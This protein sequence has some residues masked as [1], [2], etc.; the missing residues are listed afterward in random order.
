[1]G[2]TKKE[3][4]RDESKKA[5]E[6]NKTA[7]ERVEHYL[8][9]VNQDFEKLVSDSL[10]KCD[11]LV[12]FIATCMKNN[13]NGLIWGDGGFGKSDAIR[14]IINTINIQN[15]TYIMSFGNDTTESD[16]WG[17]LDMDAFFSEDQRV[18]RYKV[19]ESFLNYPFVVFEEMLDAPASALTPLKNTLQEKRL[20]LGGQTYPMLTKCIIA[21]TNKDPEEYAKKGEYVRAMME[22]FPLIYH[23]RWDSVE[24]SDYIRLYEISTKQRYDKSNFHKLLV[25]CAI[26]SHK[27]GLTISPR[28]FLA[29]C[30][31]VKPHLNSTLNASQ[32]LDIYQQLSFIQGFKKVFELGQELLTKELDEQTIQELTTK[33]IE[34]TKEITT[35]DNYVDAFSKNKMEF[36]K[37]KGRS[38]GSR[39]KINKLFSE[40]SEIGVT[41]S[42]YTT[43]DKYLNDIRNKLNNIDNKLTNILK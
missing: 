17:K 3:Q 21:L 4:I 35:L 9:Q 43:K 11:T 2:L 33:H 6:I 19:E 29:A 32:K 26:D 36:L 41:D 20:E 13:M 16:L 24:E 25:K 31:I 30:Q 34:V 42:V 8:K 5:V 12:K 28:L 10:V 14:K 22:R 27:K 15:Q 39:E 23:H 38:K 40:L 7:T 37:F 1:M 18:I